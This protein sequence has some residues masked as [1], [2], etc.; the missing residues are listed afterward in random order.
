MQ[1]SIYAENPRVI[2]TKQVIITKPLPPSGF[3][4][5]KSAYTETSLQKFNPATL[6][7]ITPSIKASTLCE[8]REGGFSS[9]SQ[10]VV[11]F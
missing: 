1:A 11:G 10:R 9:A 6:S 3:E 4:V 8:S 7:G 2:I 5:Y